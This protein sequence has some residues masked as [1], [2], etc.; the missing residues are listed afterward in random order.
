MALLR[1]TAVA[2]ATLVAAPASGE[3]QSLGERVVASDGRVAFHFKGRDGLEGCGDGSISFAG[4]HRHESRYGWSREE[5]GPGPALVVLR[6]RDREV[7]DLELRVGPRVATNHDAD[8]DLGRVSSLEAAGYLLA[9][10]GTSEARVAEDAVFPAFIAD[11]VTVWPRLIELARDRTR[12][13]DVR[14]TA[15]FWVGQEAAEVATTGLAEVARDEGEDNEIREAAVFALSQRPASEGV[16]ILMDVARTAEDADT[17]RSA[18]FWL[19]Q[20]DDPRVLEFFQEVLLQG[21]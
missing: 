8:R 14:S 13:E 10:A 4:H 17:R 15:I 11:S 6:V 9:L 7:R 21:R 20:A 2:W 18:M 5:C 19:A 12:S 3:A 16:P 1:C